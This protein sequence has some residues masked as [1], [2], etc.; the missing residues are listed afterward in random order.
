MTPDDFSRL[1][2]RTHLSRAAVEA[3]RGYLIDGET[4]LAAGIAA[5]WPAATAKQA[6][7]RAVQRIRE[8]AGRAEVCPTCRRPADSA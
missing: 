6:A 3:A 8:E 4:Y 1:A 2:A 7:W 5:G